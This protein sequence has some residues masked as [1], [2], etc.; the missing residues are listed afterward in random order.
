[1]LA[2]PR[3]AVGPLIEALRSPSI[4]VRRYSAF[5]L[6]EL[7]QLDAIPQLRVALT[8]EIELMPTSTIEEPLTGC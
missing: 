7:K 2:H 6:A 1:M 4:H 3:E 8:R 5:T